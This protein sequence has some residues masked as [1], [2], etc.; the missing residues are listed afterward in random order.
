VAAGELEDADG[1]SRTD[2]EAAATAAAGLRRA[3]LEEGGA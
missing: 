1:D 2:A 3:L